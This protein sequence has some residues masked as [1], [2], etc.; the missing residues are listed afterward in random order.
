MERCATDMIDPMVFEP[1][2]QVAGNVAR[3]VVTQ[4]PRAMS[5][6]GALEALCLE[7]EVQSVGDVLGPHRRAQLKGDDVA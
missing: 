6:L 5:D 1:F 2:R 3:P 4:Q 7:G